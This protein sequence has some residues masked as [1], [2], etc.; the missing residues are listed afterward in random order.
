MVRSIPLLGAIALFSWFGIGCT[1]EDVDLSCVEGEVRACACSDGRDGAQTCGANGTLEPCVCGAGGG[2]ATSGTDMATSD[3]DSATAADTQTNADGTTSATDGGTQ[4]DTQ[5]SAGDTATAADMGGEDTGPPPTCT[6]G[7]LD[8]F[9]AC[10]FESGC[11]EA[12][13]GD[14]LQCAIDFCADPFGDLSQPCQQCLF[15]GNQAGTDAAQ[16]VEDCDGGA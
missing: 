15:E 1:A 13:P 9:A 10:F 6:A 12:A 16:V 2:D 11:G 3:S 8:G 7:E 14:Q 4:A 5:T